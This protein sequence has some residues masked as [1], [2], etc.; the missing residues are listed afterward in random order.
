MNENNYLFEE[1]FYQ[2]LEDIFNSKNMWN[3]TTV[4]DIDF[5]K[6]GIGRIL[7]SSES[8]R[9]WVQYSIDEN[10]TPN[11][12]RSNY[13][14]IL[15]SER[16]TNI[17]SLNLSGTLNCSYELFSTSDPFANI[18]EL[19][20]YAIYA[21]DGHFHSASE[22]ERHENG[23]KYPTGHIFTIN[24]RTQQM[25]HLDLLSPDEKKEHEIKR[26]QAQ[27]ASSMRMGEPTGTKVLFIYDRAIID[28]TLWKQ[29]KNIGVYVI[30]R[31]KK[32][33]SLE[34]VSVNEFDKNNDINAGVISDEKV[35]T[36]DGV[37]I[38]KIEYFDYVRNKKYVFLTNEMKLSPGIIAFLYKTRWDI[39]KAF[40][41]FKNYFHEKKSWGK[42]ENTKR[43]QA[44]FLCIVHNL[45][46]ILERTLEIEEN[47]LD[48]KIIEKARK[49]LI[50]EKNELT[51]ANKPVN[52][53]VF[54]LRRGV[55]RSKQF[56]RFLKA[57]LYKNISW[58]AFIR[59][60]EPYMMKYI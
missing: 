47:I 51:E 26:I 19:K 43:Q 57:K 46:L 13:F 30:T 16:R 45:N 3:N 38:R 5:I 2:P 41:G 40:D 29:W 15:K 42:A 22:H 20:G 58:Q 21:G 18:D 6:N 25:D 32:N 23:K 17:A 55:L 28:Y 59:H 49:K 52:L 50:K 34:F 56:I 35:K 31:A 27:N 14:D 7:S 1:K 36:K 24:L 48:E 53:L 9:E 4:S 37:L 12:T 11:L 8:G 54:T 60:V 39:E 44:I 33:S 10:I